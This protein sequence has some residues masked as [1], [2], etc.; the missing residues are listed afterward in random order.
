[1]F[2]HV[3]TTVGSVQVNFG[4]FSIWS[5]LVLHLEDSVADRHDVI[6]RTLDDLDLKGEAVVD[7]LCKEV[8]LLDS[9]VK[10]GLSFRRTC[11]LA[12]SEPCSVSVVP[13]RHKHAVRSLHNVTCF[14]TMSGDSFLV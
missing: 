5:V 3:T 8:S 11:A 14:V 2:N 4:V 10:F 9:H 12:T 7:I 1:M 13:D 6:V